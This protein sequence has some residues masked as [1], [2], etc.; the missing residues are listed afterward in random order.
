MYPKISRKNVL[1]YMM[2]KRE[3]VYAFQKSIPIIPGYIFL[4]IAFGVTLQY[5]GYGPVWALLAS[6]FIYAG[7]MQF[8]LVS[9]LLSQ[10]SLIY[11]A[12]MTLFINGR[13][14]FYGLSFIDKFRKMGKYFLYMVFSL[15]DETY[16]VLCDLKTPEEMD[17][18]RISFLI[19]AFDQCYWVIGSVTG[20]LLGSLIT[21]DVTGIDFSMTALFVVIVINQWLDNKDHRPALVGFVTGVICLL[22]FGKDK[23]ILPALLITVIILIGARK[24]WNMQ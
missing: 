16:S 3:I 10:A 17:E 13:H 1:R 22:I 12:I 21:F 19:S 20:A 15:T 4:G 2:R 8:V 6:L 7:S 11:T 5:A 14:F 9:L 24:K 23:F 18:K